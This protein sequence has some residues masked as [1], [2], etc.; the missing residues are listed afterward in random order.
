MLL[1]KKLIIGKHFPHN[2]TILFLPMVNPDGLA[3]FGAF[4]RINQD[5]PEEM[6]WRVT[7]QNLNLNRDFVKA[8]SPEMQFWLKFYNIWLP[9]FTIDCHVTD[10]ADYQY[11]LTYVMETM[12]NMDSGLTEWQNQYL[13]F[14]EPTMA[15][16]GYPI[17]PYVTFRRWHD[18]RSGLHSR[19]ARPML[20][21]GYTA[22]QNRVGLLLEAHSLKPFDLRVKAML[23]L[24]EE[25]MDYIENRSEE[26]VARGKEAD[27]ATLLLTKNNDS[28]PLTFKPTEKCD[29]VD[30]LGVEYDV[31]TSDLTGGDWFLYKP[32]KPV[33]FRLPHYNTVEPAIW[34]NVPAAFIVGP[35]WHFL[36]QRLDIHKIKY[37][38]LTENLEF[39]AETWRCTNP[40]W[41]QN[42]FEGRFLLTDV[43]LKT[44]LIKQHW[45]VGS[46]VIP[47]NQR[48][49]RLI[50]HM[51]N[52]NAPDSYLRM[53]YMNG[54]FEQREYFETYVMEP[55]ARKMLDT[56]PGLSERFAAW[57]KEQPEVPGSYQQLEWFYKQTPYYDFKRNVYPVS[58]LSPE[59]LKTME[60]NIR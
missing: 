53:G 31:I 30:F 51:L 5:G 48:R 38:R 28:L 40:K 4:N 8:D 6:G 26:L 27:E 22:I 12:G 2:V 14:L 56:I 36:K 13:G 47:L 57:K 20:S 7:A 58:T 25:T 19:P 59:Q 1:I 41:A 50:M 24:F 37:Y 42:P 46:L 21:N 54:I 45:P 16:A 23:Q 49:A 35:E 32:D 3:R 52:P 33:T 11:V 55:M 15:K 60:P 39:E 18:P 9:D 29:T 43:E 10:G 44:D 34:A 17:F